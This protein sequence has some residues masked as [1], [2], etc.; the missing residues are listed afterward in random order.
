MDKQSAV[1]AICKP[2]GGREAMTSPPGDVTE[3]P[4]PAIE[5]LWTHYPTC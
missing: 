4:H 2:A 5:E 1:A 3:T